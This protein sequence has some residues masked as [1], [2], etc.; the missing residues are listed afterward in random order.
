MVSGMIEVDRPTTEAL[1]QAI[2]DVVRAHYRARP[3]GRD[4]VLE[5]LN[6]LAVIT[7]VVIAGTGCDPDAVEFFR[8]AVAQNIEV[9]GLDTALN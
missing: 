5:A 9:N 1:T 8:E 6:A 3:P 7:A 2:G 4:R